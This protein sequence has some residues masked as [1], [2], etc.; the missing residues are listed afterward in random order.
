MTVT[1]PPAEPLI[2]SSPGTAVDP[3]ISIG[4]MTL[5][6]SELMLAAAEIAMR[7]RGASAVAVHAT[8][9]MST[10][11][12][13]VGCLIAGVP[14]VPVPPDAGIS[15]R[16]HILNDSGAALW[17]GA[18]IDDLAIES[19]PVDPYARS[20]V[21]TA[22]IA[23][24]RTALV[25]YTSGTT[26]PPKGAVISRRAVAACLDGLADAWDWTDDDVLVRLPGA[27]GSDRRRW[28]VRDR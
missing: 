16:Q 6:R 27:P 24:D 8:P 5:R 3:T 28:L 11:V 2:P 23:K 14:V 4:D 17:L 13:T 20:D 18:S 26:G 19:I 15:E 10:V 25:M 12:S 1:D 21:P 22:A 9:T 7:V